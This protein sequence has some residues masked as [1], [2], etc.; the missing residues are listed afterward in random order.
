MQ[1]ATDSLPPNHDRLVHIRAGGSDVSPEATSRIFQRLRE[2]A[3]AT[4]VRARL[5][6][7]QPNARLLVAMGESAP[8]VVPPTPSSAPAT[9]RLQL[10]LGVGPSARPAAVRPTPYPVPPAPAVSSQLP[11][12]T[13]RIINSIPLP[14]APPSRNLRPTALADASATYARQRAAA[15]AAGPEPEMQLKANV[16]NMMALGEALNEASEFGINSNTLKK[17]DRAWSFWETVCKRM[18]TSPLRTPEEVRNNPE[19]QSFLLAIL[20]MYASAVCV[21]KTPGRQCIKPRSALAYPL[22]IIRIFG[23]WGITMPGFRHIKAALHGLMRQ[24]LLYHGPHSL[25]PKRAEPMRFSMVQ[26]INH[27]VRNGTHRIHGLVW[28]DD[29]HLVFMFLRLNL[30][31]M[32]TAFR[33]AEIVAHSSGEIM[34][35][36]RS[37]V[38]LNLSGVVIDDPTPAQLDSMRP[39]VDKVGITPPR[40]KPDQWGEIHCPFPVYLTYYDEPENPAKA[41]IDIERRIPCRGLARQATPLFADENGQPYTHARLDGLLTAVLTY[42]FSAAVAAIFTFH[43]YRSGLATALF[44]ADVPDGVIML[45]CRWMCPESLHVYRRMTAA[46]HDEYLRRSLQSTSPVCRA[47]MCRAPLETLGMPNSARPSPALHSSNR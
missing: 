39:G 12:L 13:N 32:Y 38:H 24:Y 34:Y 47:S 8:A 2:S 19:R 18:D 7:P 1:F 17:D 9:S 29:T 20:M 43:S 36:T 40:S 27:L 41:I 10:L 11:P 35:L 6:A 16:A 5:P 23:R 30:F 45:M 44:A 25:Q 37:D 42:L 33:L 46:K 26:K 28:S 21:P 22:A 4:N 31:L 15:L 14:A 3:A